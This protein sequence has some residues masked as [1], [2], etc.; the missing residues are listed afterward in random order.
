[1]GQLHEYGDLCKCDNTYWCEL[2][3]PN[4]FQYGLD[5]VDK[6]YI[7]NWNTMVFQDLPAHWIYGL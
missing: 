4:V 1:M 6:A 7:I 5:E 3:V 2:H